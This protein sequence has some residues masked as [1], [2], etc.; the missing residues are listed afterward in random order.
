MENLIKFSITKLLFDATNRIMSLC[1]RIDAHLGVL[2]TIPIINCD[3]HYNFYLRCFVRKYSHIN[4]EPM[5][6]SIV[7][8]SS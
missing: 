2:E 7:P 4:R 8:S 5:K 1:I 6:T 3:A